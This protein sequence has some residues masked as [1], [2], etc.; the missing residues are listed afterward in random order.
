MVG[1]NFHSPAKPH[2]QTYTET[3]MPVKTVHTTAA[4]KAGVAQTFIN[5]KDI[6]AEWWYLFHSQDLNNLI[7][8]GLANNPTLAASYASLQSLKRH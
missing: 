1:P 6:P 7:T 8:T 3:R 4:G 5:G 2:V